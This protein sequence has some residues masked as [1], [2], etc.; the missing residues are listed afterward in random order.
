MEKMTI[1]KYKVSGTDKS[2]EKG[3][4]WIFNA[5]PIVKLI[6]GFQT[7]EQTKHFNS[8]EDSV[9]TVTATLIANVVSHGLIQKSLCKPA[10]ER[11]T[12]IDTRD[13]T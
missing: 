1:G 13:P 4:K 11:R 9:P 8:M 2:R 3:F 6:V 12:I 7:K 5:D 10:G